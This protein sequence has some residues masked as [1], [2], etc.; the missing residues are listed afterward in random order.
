MF[1]RNVAEAYDS[2]FESTLGAFVDQTE[3]R[4]AFSLLAPVAGERILDV[5]CG[6]GNFSLKLASQKCLV[7]GVDRSEDMLT[8]A[9]RRADEEG[10]S[11]EFLLGDGEALPFDDGSFDGVITMATLEFVQAPVRILGEMLR[12]LVP[13][14]RVL[15]GAINRDSPWGTLYQ[16]IGKK[17]DPVFKDARLLSREELAGLGTQGPAKNAPETI[18]GCL[19]V[20]PDLPEEQI[21]WEAEEAAA[22]GGKAPGFLCAIWRKPS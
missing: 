1:D 20:P 18:E 7:T 11:I 21:G 17:G 5:G 4:C 13:G 14:G 16:Q 10:R 15:V 6:T 8:V 9:R 22:A 12:V 3:T 2:W 19:F